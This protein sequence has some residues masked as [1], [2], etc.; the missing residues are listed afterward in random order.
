MFDAHA[1]THRVLIV[2]DEFVPR[3]I[4]SFALEGTGRYYTI[5]AGNAADALTLLAEDHYDC[6]VIDLSMP[7]MS[8]IELITLIR[9]QLAHRSLPIVLVLPEEAEGATSTPSFPGPTH[10]ITKPFQPWDLARLLD[11]LTGDIEDSQHVL[12]VEA[13]LRGFP[14][15]TMILDAGHHVLLANAAFYDATHTGVGECYIACMNEM[16]EDNRV[17]SSCP[18]ERCVANNETAEEL[19]DTVFGR[20]RTSVYPLA[21]RTGAGEQLYLHVTQPVDC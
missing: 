12:S 9:R 11:S 16:H 14:Y 3:S 5:E 1:P 13:V 19:I 17:P 4:E 18:L 10:M 15:P 6:A 8:G 7:D 21:I 2:D 20:M